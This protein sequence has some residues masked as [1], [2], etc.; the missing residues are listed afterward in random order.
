MAEIRETRSST[1][2]PTSGHPDRG[3]G[4]RAREQVGVSAAPIAV[5]GAG[6]AHR[7]CRGG[8]ETEFDVVLADAGR[9]RST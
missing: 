9:A 7:R 1:T 2:F 6:A 3:V 5:A 4:E 8:G